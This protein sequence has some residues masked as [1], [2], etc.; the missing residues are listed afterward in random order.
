MVSGG[1]ECNVTQCYVL[2]AGKSLIS[3]QCYIVAFFMELNGSERRRS[4]T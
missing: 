4:G 1:G 2:W 3:K